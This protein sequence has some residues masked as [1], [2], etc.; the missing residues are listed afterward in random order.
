MA[1]SKQVARDRTLPTAPEQDAPERAR[2]GGR[3]GFGLGQ[4]ADG[5]LTA[6]GARRAAGAAGNDFV[7]DLVG[8]KRGGGQRG[9]NGVQI[10][11]EANVGSNGAQGS[12]E[13]AGALQVGGLQIGGNLR[14]GGGRDNGAPARG[15]E[16]SGRGKAAPAGPEAGGRGAAAPAHGGGGNGGGANGAG[17]GGSAASVSGGISVNARLGGGDAGG[18]DDTLAVGGFSMRTAGGTAGGGGAPAGRPGA[19]PAGGAPPAAPGGNGGAGGGGAAGSARG[20]GAGGRGGASR[21]GGG[22]GRGGFGLNVSAGGLSASVSDGGAS[23]S[24]QGGGVS[25]SVSNEGASVSAGGVSA[26]VSERGASARVRS[27]GTSVAAN[28]GSGTASVAVSTGGSAGTAAA[29]TAAGAERA[30][31]TTGTGAS[32]RTGTGGASGNAAGGARAPRGGGAGGARSGGGAAGGRSGGGGG[33]RR[34]GGGGGGGGGRAAAAPVPVGN[35]ESAQGAMNEF[36]GGSPTTQ[37]KMWAS[38]GGAVN[39]G[40]Q[41]DGV[42]IQASIPELHA[43]MGG[44]GQQPQADGRKTEVKAGQGKIDDKKVSPDAP[45]VRPTPTVVPAAPRVD[46]A[47]AMNG[48]T[49]ETPVEQKQARARETIRAIPTTMEG[50]PTTPGPAPRV[51]LTGDADPAKAEANRADADAQVQKGAADLRAAV[52]NGRGPDAVQ[53]KVFDEVHQVRDLVEAKADATRETDPLRKYMQLGI[54]ADVEGAI[55]EQRQQVM[56]TALGEARG[57]MDEA[58]SKKDADSTKEIESANAEAETMRAQAEAQQQEAV[59]KARGDISDARDTTLAEQQKAVA[60]LESEA[61]SKQSQ[62]VAA[63][64]ARVSQDEA[65]IDDAYAKAET[66]VTKKIE[67]GEKDAEAEKKKAEEEANNRSWWDRVKDAVASAFKALTDAINS[68]LNW[69]RDAV[70]AILDGV[71]KLA[72][73][74]IDAAA[75]WITDKLKAFGDWLKSQVTALLGSVFPELAKKLNEL[76][77]AAVNYACEK[78]EQLADTLKAGI[79]ALCDKIAGALDAIIAIYQAAVNFAMTLA[80]AALT[81]NWA[82]VGMIVL[83]GILKLAGIP[84][85]EF[86]AVI[87]KA[88]DTIGVIVE[89]PGGFLGNCIDAVGQGFG[90]FSDNFLGHLQEGFLSWMTGTMGDAGITMPATFDLAGIFDLVMQVTGLTPEHLR[91]KAVEHIGEEN[92][93]RVEFVWGFISSALEGGWGGLFE[94]VEEHLGNLWDDVVGAIQNFLMEKIIKSAVLKIASM[95]NPVGAIVQAIMTAWNLYEFLRDQIQRIFGVVRAVVDS[96]SDIAAGNIGGAA[97]MIEN[98]LGNLVPVAIDLLAKLLG[99]GGISQKIKDVV[100]KV[101]AKVDN[102]IDKLIEKVKGLFKGGKKDGEKE[103]DESAEQSA[104]EKAADEKKDEGIANGVFQFETAKLVARD[105][106]LGAVTYSIKGSG[107]VKK[108]GGELDEQAVAMAKSESM[109]AST[110]A[111]GKAVLEAGGVASIDITQLR[112]LSDKAKVNATKGLSG[113]GLALDA[114]SIDELVLPP[115]VRNA[116]NDAAAARVLEGADTPIHFQAGGENHRLWVDFSGGAA[117]AM[118]ASTPTPVEER[119]KIWGSQLASLPREDKQKAGRAIGR[120]IAIQRAIAQMGAPQKGTAEEKALEDKKQELAGAAQVMFDLLPESLFGESRTAMTPEMTLQSQ[121]YKTFEARFVDF[122]NQAGLTPEGGPQSQAQK[123]WMELVTALYNTQG[124]MAALPRSADGRTQV[125]LA[126]KAAQEMLAKF[127]PVM[128]VMLPAARKLHAG[129]KSWA[130][131][132]GAPAMEIAKA[133]AEVALESSAIAGPFDG[134]RVPRSLMSIQMWFALSQAYANLAAKE[135]GIRKFSNF[136]GAGSNNPTSVFNNIENPTLKAV[137]NDIQFTYYACVYLPSTNGEKLPDTRFSA[138][139][140][141]GAFDSAAGPDTLRGSVAEKASRANAERQKRFED[142]LAAGATERDAQAALAPGWEGRQMPGSGPKAQARADQ[143]VQ[144]PPAGG[145]L[146]AGVGGVGQGQGEGV[147]APVGPANGN[148]E[149]QGH[150]VPAVPLAQDRGPAPTVG[151]GGRGGQVEQADVVVRG[152]DVQA[153]S[154]SA[155]AEPE[156]AR[157]SRFAAG[158]PPAGWRGEIHTTRPAFNEPGHTDNILNDGNV[159]RESKPK[160]LERGV[161]DGAIRAAGLSKGALA[162]K[163]SP[164]DTLR[165]DPRMSAEEVD[166]MKGALKKN[167]RSE[168]VLAADGSTSTVARPD[169]VDALSGKQ[170][171]NAVSSDGTTRAPMTEKEKAALLKGHALLAEDNKEGADMRKVIPNNGVGAMLAGQPSPGAEK[172]GPSV[173]GSVGLAR[174]T[175]GMNA[176]ETV[177]ALGLDYEHNPSTDAKPAAGKKK[178]GS[179]GNYT[180][181]DSSGKVTVSDEVE[182][183]GL[184]YL[185]FKMTKEMEQHAGVAMSQ[186]LIDKAKASKDP[187]VAALGTRGHAQEKSRQDDPFAATGATSSNALVQKHGAGAGQQFDTVLNQELNLNPKRKSAG[188]GEA[189]FELEAGAQLKKRGNK[190]GQDKVIATLVE[191]ADKDGKIVKE[192]E[193]DA[194]LEKNERGHYKNKMDK[195]KS[196]AAATLRKPGETDAE[197]KQRMK[198]RGD[199]IAAQKQ[200][201]EAEAAANGNPFEPGTPEFKSYNRKARAKAKAKADS[202]EAKPVAPNGDTSVAPV[203]DEKPVVTAAPPVAE[204][205]KEAPKRAAKTAPDTDTAPDAQVEAAKK[206]DAKS[207]AEEIEKLLSPAAKAKP[208]KESK[209]PKDFPEPENDTVQGTGTT[210]GTTT[211][212]DTTTRKVAANPGL[213][214]EHEGTGVE[215]VE[216]KGEA[217]VKGEGDA[218]D[219]DPNDV[220]QGSLGDCYLLGGMAAVSRANPEHIRKLIKDNGDG[221]YDVTL[222]I[223]D[224]AWSS[225]GTAKVVTVDGKF[226]S[227][228]KGLSAKYAKAGDKGAKGPELWCMLIEKAWAV[229]KGTYTGIEGGKVN[230]DG[231]FA[232]AI[233]LLTNLKEGYYTPA[234]IG[235]KQLAQMIADAL[236]KK[237]PV[238]C[239]SKNLDKEPPDL[240]A[241]AD[242]AGVVGNH[243]YAPKSVDL[244]A[245]TIELQNPWG[246]SHVSGLKIADFKRFYRGLRI[247]S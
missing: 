157:V 155:P 132:S 237:M 126:D 62:E 85:E 172:L 66:D 229:H 193:L 51:P 128:D 234:S 22:R 247:G 47:R 226:P 148:V 91:E 114:L 207:P 195:A 227:G 194:G 52:E 99:L 48:V 42:A 125:N 116:L 98:A 139:G 205:S 41:K 104:E 152:G 13:V 17:N 147:R 176:E 210:T 130:F 79:A 151:Q 240:K 244:Q 70:K 83:E 81:G 185:D 209:P 23:V 71:K 72:T 110:G 236:S 45:K 141:A 159:V 245:M 84:P 182:R 215:Y 131:W 59:G 212:T 232:G 168:E 24:Y 163:K 166:A 58:V 117:V 188:P 94:H 103:E 160:L 191:K 96:I 161:A 136:L 102:A 90:Q 76:I 8:G 101:Q 46:G 138:N 199:K 119:A 196:D 27:G 16:P 93:E 6:G 64:R 140:V 206:K 143:D 43:T 5:L 189:G 198:D 20:G 180:E 29:T 53:P 219:I 200:K 37:V 73:D 44:G 56:D 87:G 228:D 208:P 238:A 88:E 218:A 67:E 19:P 142:A 145:R 38:V 197:Y 14:I 26:S 201:D 34:A 242:A 39:V 235:D 49:A 190:A 211:T 65:K 95:F 105:N 118:V 31:G 55:D 113:S 224:N 63:I 57:K 12:V 241:A 222:Y 216:M 121:Q 220:K 192:W 239:D 175:E 61:S 111:V 36:L 167:P 129:A 109:Q 221:T 158:D 144:A 21:G 77:D 69:V 82:K 164:E 86:Y 214:K 183:D 178:K 153:A 7:S 217:F 243:A 230:D 225:K 146:P 15:Q 92:V 231:K 68:I 170:L 202:A 1:R 10:N 11:A 149:A 133:N 80:E 115:E 74:L 187:K 40:I 162:K 204:S 9:G 97:D 156:N 32:A 127:Q 18:A 89:N 137:A 33:G 165:A 179:W 177:A 54:P 181:M 171:T 108:E 50:V 4:V 35:T 184:H 25:A 169:K 233:A 150:A 78:V 100:K 223:K 106:Q 28:A 173:R 3:R 154:G 122:C 107:R 2:G 186:D 120:V 124:D 213:R 112:P 134:L 75:K 135:M 123:A 30:G 246:S 203:K 174:N 60:Q